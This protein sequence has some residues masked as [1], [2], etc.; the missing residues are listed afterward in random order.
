MNNSY[1]NLNSKSYLN[2]F[3][4][5]LKEIIFEVYFNLLKVSRNIKFSQMTIATV[6]IIEN[7]EIMIFTFFTFS[8]YQSDFTN[9]FSEIS[10]FYLLIKRII[11]IYS[12]YNYI[13]SRGINFS[14][15]VFYVI[16]A[17]Y[18]IFTITSKKRCYMFD[19][20]YIFYLRVFQPI[21]SLPVMISLF[22]LICDLSTETNENLN[23]P[24]EG[25]LTNF[26]ISIITLSLMIL[27]QIFRSLFFSD[28]NPYFISVQSIYSITR[29]ISLIIIKLILAF[30]FS[31]MTTSSL[32]YVEKALLISIIIFIF[33][34]K[35]IYVFYKTKISFYIE[36]VFEFSWLVNCLLNIFITVFEIKLDAIIICF[37]FLF[38]IFGGV[39]VIFIFK[40][41]LH[42]LMFNDLSNLSLIESV[43]KINSLLEH[44]YNQDIQLK[45]VIF[46]LKDDIQNHLN[47]FH[48]DDNLI[49]SNC[50]CLHHLKEINFNIIDKINITNIEN[51]QAEVT[52]RENKKLLTVNISIN[53]SE[54]IDSDLDE[55]S[56]VDLVL[57]RKLS[58]TPSADNSSNLIDKS[59]I[60]TIKKEQENII[61]LIK[62]LEQEVNNQKLDDILKSTNLN[63]EIEYSIISVILCMIKRTILKYPSCTTIKLTYSELIM[64]K[65]KNYNLAMNEIKKINQYSQNIFTNYQL[66][67]LRHLYNDFIISI[68]KD[69]NSIIDS[70]S[71]IDYN[72]N[73]EKLYNLM[74]NYN[75]TLRLLWFIVNENNTSFYYKLFDYSIELNMICVEIRDIINSLYNCNNYLST[76]LINDIKYFTNEICNDTDLLIKCNEI[77]DK[78]KKTITTAEVSSNSLSKKKIQNTNA[79]DTKISKN[80]KF[81]KD[82]ATTKSISDFLSSLYDKYDSL[83][84]LSI[85]SQPNAIGRITN[86]NN[87][88]LEKLYY[89]KSQ[90]IN[91]NINKIIVSL[92]GHMHDTFIKR[93]I[94]T[95]RSYFLNKHILTYFKNKFNV[96]IVSNSFLK[97]S[98]YIKNGISFMSAISFI[99]QNTSILKYED[100]YTQQ[101]S[102]SFVE[103]ITPSIKNEVNKTNDAASNIYKYLSN[104]EVSLIVTTDFP[105]FFIVGINKSAL[106]TFGIP[107]NVVLEF[108][109]NNYNNN[110]NVISFKD[111]LCHKSILDDSNLGNLKI[112]NIYDIKSNEGII[113]KIDTK[114][115]SS[116]YQD[117]LESITQDD[118]GFSDDVKSSTNKLSTFSYINLSFS[119]FIFNNGMN[120]LLIFRL[121]K[122]T[123]LISENS[124][125]EILKNYQTTSP[126]SINLSSTQKQNS[127]SSLTNIKP[128]VTANYF[129][130]AEKSSNSNLL[131][132]KPSNNNFKSK[133]N[134]DRSE[135]YN[136]KISIFN[137]L[138]VSHNSFILHILSLY[139]MNFFIVFL[140]MMILFILETIFSLRFITLCNDFVAIDTLNN[141]QNSILSLLMTSYTL[142]SNKGIINTDT[143]STEILHND[144][145]YYLSSIDTLS[146][147]IRNSN[148]IPNKSIYLKEEIVFSKLFYNNTDNLGLNYSQITSSY[149]YLESNILIKIQKALSN[150][151]NHI[152]YTYVLENYNN[153]LL[154]EMVIKFK[155]SLSDMFNDYYDNT[156]F[157]ILQYTPLIL[158][159]Y[160]LVINLII[161]PKIHRTKRNLINLITKTSKKIVNNKIKSSTNFLKYVDSKIIALPLKLK[162]NLNNSIDSENINIEKK[163]ST[164]QIVNKKS[165]KNQITGEYI[166]KS[167]SINRSPQKQSNIKKTFVTRRSTVTNEKKEESISPKPAN[168]NHHLRS[169]IKSREQNPVNNTSKSLF[170]KEE[171]NKYEVNITSPNPKKQMQLNTIK[172]VHGSPIKDQ[173]NTSKKL[174]KS[175]IIEDENNS[176]EENE[177]IN[178]FTKGYGIDSIYKSKTQKVILICV[179]QILIIMFTFII[180]YVT[181]ILIHDSFLSKLN[182]HND[183]L[184]S[185]RAMRFNNLIYLSSKVLI[186][187][188]SCE[189]KSDI[190]INTLT[191]NTDICDSLLF[192]IRE[193]EENENILNVFRVEDYPLLSFLETK[194][195]N[196][197]TDS[198]FCLEVSSLNN[199]NDK[200]VEIWN[201]RN[202][203]SISQ[204]ETFFNTLN[205][206]KILINKNLKDII[207]SIKSY[208]YFNIQNKAS[209]SFIDN[210]P[211]YYLIASRYVNPSIYYFQSQVYFLLQDLFTSEEARVIIQ[212]LV[213]VIFKLFQM[214]MVFWVY[215]R[216][217]SNIRKEMTLISILQLESYE[218]TEELIGIFK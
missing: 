27:F 67:K 156:L 96:L 38:W 20:F 135:R 161:F 1:E 209:T 9:L 153:L 207:Q 23:Y 44:Y 10:S 2:E 26:I 166:K 146:N 52:D 214:S 179:I 41:K 6:L 171:S 144:I 120:K 22:N 201:N 75:E 121:I 104:K 37:S 57:Q 172:L 82:E 89:Q 138:K 154:P 62:Q 196:F 139:K 163:E 54:S 97:I 8:F 127:K 46:I 130:E 113:T 12:D 136:L 164:P 70:K 150:I 116:N 115:L 110:K 117:Y 81:E 137:Y 200:G 149:F 95:N 122:L 4:R 76:D 48:K 204:C 17:L 185:K 77:Q 61:N 169:S 170:F 180:Y 217:R 59:K 56:L 190:I 197:N 145:S 155:Y 88:F 128:S 111:I 84:Y 131:N 32:F 11:V 87:V 19:Y 18:T 103:T 35:S 72:S 80:D 69:N 123:P 102:N 45:D 132:K 173:V 168:K 25:N 125:Q 133:M 187:N 210:Y 74:K 30:N 33:I 55:N 193:L 71:F 49:L 147:I 162:S 134:S 119:P 85:S 152:D 112:K 129:N 159:L 42:N 213:F 192:I 203:I 106:I 34:M 186:E 15:F 90:L 124:N 206:K 100:Y 51:N 107:L 178:I 165:I 63:S 101:N 109:D 99:K 142:I 13:L 181:T 211:Y 83:G 195:I 167:I 216:L 177:E 40:R 202:Q 68:L 65:Y 5:F 140:L 92:F 47:L 151:T 64:F 184:F 43:S 29:S 60:I 66:Y 91:F 53:D 105:N 198:Q 31:K 194:L 158:S 148:I 188:K 141:L 86:V 212:V 79:N 3:I 118:Y 50:D 183:S 175:N 126:V 208:I 199:I 58:V 21:L 114:S 143:I 39:T 215:Y 160:I 205:S 73:K 191:N 78:V 182:K 24:C 93:Y 108:S 98:P 174:D 36:T 176:I 189:F 7:L 157:L 218:N 16:L 28:P 14:F 94:E